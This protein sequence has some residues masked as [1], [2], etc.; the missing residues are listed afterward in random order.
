MQAPDGVGLGRVRLESTHPP[1]MG[2]YRVADQSRQIFDYHNRSLH[3]FVGVLL[4]FIHIIP[5]ISL[6]S[7]WSFGDAAAH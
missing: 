1:I 2:I 3:R 5:A 6:A 4:D 7:R